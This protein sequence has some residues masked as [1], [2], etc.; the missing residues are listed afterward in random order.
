MLLGKKKFLGILLAISLMFGLFPALGP[1]AHAAYAPKHTG[2]AEALNA[3]GLFKGTGTDAGGRPVFALERTATRAEAL[4]MLLRLLGEGSAAQAW[5]GTQP[6]RDVPKS[7]WAYKYVGYAYSKGYTGG[8]S[9]VTFAPNTPANANMYLTFVLRALGYSDARGDFT[10]SQAAQKAAAIGLV[11]DGAYTGGTF[12]RDDC[13]Y[14]SYRALTRMLSGSDQTLVQKLEA[15][16]AVSAGE[17]AAQGL[18]TGCGVKSVSVKDDVVTVVYSAPAGCTLRAAFSYPDGTPAGEASAALSQ[19]APSADGTASVTLS[20][21]LPK[22][23]DLTVTVENAYKAGIGELTETGLTGSGKLVQPVKTPNAKTVNAANVA[24]LRAALVSGSDIRLTGKTYD[25]GDRPLVLE[26]LKNIR[27]SSA[28]GTATITTG[29]DMELIKMSGCQNIEL[30][31]LKIYRSTPK[32]DGNSSCLEA[33]ACRDLSVVGCTFSGYGRTGWY[34][35]DSAVTFTGD[36]IRNCEQAVLIAADSQVT[37][38]NCT[39]SDNMVEHGYTSGILQ[40]SDDFGVGYLD[41]TNDSYLETHL[42]LSNCSF[43]NNGSKNFIT[44]EFIR[45]QDADEQ[46]Y[47]SAEQSTRVKASGCVFSGN[48]WQ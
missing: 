12:Y 41:M 39:V 45:N 27:I 14:V 19:T 25:L 30:S 2:E 31:G 37:M 4:T 28:G 9:A 7:S 5:S 32:S 36:T 29:K 10:Y 38:T 21:G 20:G 34:V 42:T 24:E 16:G 44:E 23:F 1:A 15:A 26:D 46:S 48:A 8:T 40:V 17:A 13:A 11:P 3:L 6:F 43:S 22:S 35:S 18:E 47:A 33:I